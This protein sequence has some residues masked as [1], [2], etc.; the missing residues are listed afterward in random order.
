MAVSKRLRYEVLRRDNHACRYCGAAAPDAKLTVDHVIPTALGGSDDPGNLVAACV[1]CNAGKS[2]SNPDAPLVG[3]VSDAALRWGRA[4]A[5]AADTMATKL[6][7][8]RDIQAAFLDAWE[9][10]KHGDPIKLWTVPLDKNWRESLSALLRRGL[11]LEVVI[12]CIGVAMRRDAVKLPDKFRYFC[13]V[14]WRKVDE[15]VEA[16]KGIY[17]APASSGGPIG[18][19]DP[20]VTALLPYRD[21]VHLLYGAMPGP[22]DDEEHRRILAADFDR[23]HADDE[24]E[25]GVRVD[26]SW[27]PT[28]LCAFVTLVHH[29]RDLMDKE[30]RV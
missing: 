1:D 18:L 14:A 15:L 10:W 4:V 7:S 16:A 8:E 13:G 19:P 5:E 28:D 21:A 12:D 24:D 3:D 26:R 23:A 27:W 11:P 30:A 29:M 20:A 9:D 17:D 25:T 22:F 2:S 6:A